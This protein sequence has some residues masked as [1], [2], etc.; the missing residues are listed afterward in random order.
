MQ[1]I[2]IDDRAEHRREEN[3]A[4]KDKAKAECTHGQN[5]VISFTELW[6]II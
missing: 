4:G 6:H 1:K 5:T 3:Q 2:K